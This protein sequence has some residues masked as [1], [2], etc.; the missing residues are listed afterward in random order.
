MKRQPRKSLQL[1]T[2]MLRALHDVQLQAVDGAGAGKA[3]GGV[4]G[5]GNS[6]KGGCNV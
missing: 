1:D 4:N 3:T 2:Q 5:K 6:C